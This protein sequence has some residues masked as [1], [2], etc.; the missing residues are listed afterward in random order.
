MEQGIGLGVADL[1]VEPLS[2][3]TVSI[4][5]SNFSSA[6]PTG[7]PTSSFMAAQCSRCWNVE[8]AGK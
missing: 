3:M 7:W 1:P 2:A 4:V 8:R 6:N 5:E